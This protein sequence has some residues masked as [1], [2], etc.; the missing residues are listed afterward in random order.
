[1]KVRVWADSSAGPAVRAVAQPVVVWA[2]ESS[3][4]VTSAPGVKL[5]SSLTAVTVM[6][7]VA[8]VLVAPSVSVM[9]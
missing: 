1:M 9:V 2:P 7:T 6:V 8:G 4:T 3:V 5:G